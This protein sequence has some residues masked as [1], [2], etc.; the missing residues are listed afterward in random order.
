MP[1]LRAYALLDAELCIDQMRY[2]A[3]TFNY[4]R[5]IDFFCAIHP[6]KRH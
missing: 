3:N 1:R 4:L 5:R 2:K 6:E